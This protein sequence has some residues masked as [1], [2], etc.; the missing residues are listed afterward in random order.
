MAPDGKVLR[1]NPAACA[2]FAMSEEEL[3][4]VGRAELVAP[5]ETR[6]VAL[7]EAR[8]EIGK[9][10]GELTMVRS[11]GSRFDAEV[12]TSR[13][14]MSD[15]TLLANVVL[16]DVTER[17]QFQQEILLLNAELGRRVQQRTA[18]LE[19][20]NAELK[21]FAHSLAHDLRASIAA[22][23]GFSGT[24][25]LSLAQSGAEREQHYASRIH[26]ASQRMDEFVEALLSLASV[27]QA[28]MRRT[29]VDLSA[30]AESILADLHERDRA[31]VVL[32]T[33]QEGLQAVGDARL[34]RMALEN[35]LGNA[36][37]FTSQRETAEI[38][39]NAQP[40]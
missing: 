9:A 34:L 26:A 1:A 17:L 29:E 36:W 39:F 23:K 30:I 22:I 16:R 20:A 24:L 28:E 25:E 31:R 12:T 19:T 10:V 33:T 5:E 14:R 7:V 37:K 8:N 27:S 11:D 35:L 40:P 18:E 3:E 21:G 13:F 38:A 6:L 32:C 15:G 2:M 4:K